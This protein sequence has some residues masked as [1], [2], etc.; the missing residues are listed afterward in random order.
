MPP[1]FPMKYERKEIPVLTREMLLKKI[2]GQ[3]Y[4]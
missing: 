3:I 2:R 1:R 4:V